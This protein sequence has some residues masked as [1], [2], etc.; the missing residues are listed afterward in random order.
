MWYNITR[1]L[2]HGRRKCENAKRYTYMNSTKDDHE[3]QKENSRDERGAWKDW[4]PDGLPMI[5][6]FST[7]L[8]SATRKIH[9]LQGLKSEHAGLG[10]SELPNEWCGECQVAYMDK[11]TCIDK[12][13]SRNMYWKSCHEHRHT[14]A[15]KEVASKVNIVKPV[16]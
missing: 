13:E 16:I 5:C 8:W 1:I 7:H 3:L 9:K 4:A 14:G 15:C 6:T 10:E 12:S 2:Y 11:H